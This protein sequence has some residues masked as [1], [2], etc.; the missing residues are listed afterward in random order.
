MLAY[1]WAILSPGLLFWD[2]VSPSFP[3]G[4]WTYNPPVIDSQIDEWNYRS[5]PPGQA[6][7]VFLQLGL[8][9]NRWIKLDSIMVIFKWWN[10]YPMIQN[11]QIVSLFS[12]FKVY[13][14]AGGRASIN[15]PSWPRTHYV[16]Q[17]DF[18]SERSAYLCLVSTEVKGMY[19]HARP[20]PL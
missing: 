5:V 15:N 18:N 14:D 10:T 4:S 20:T 19:H 8:Y 3:G 7:N 1:Q 2:K 12:F 11:T 6:K 17:A 13:W 9:A 16:H